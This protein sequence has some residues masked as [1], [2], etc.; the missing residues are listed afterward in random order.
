MLRHAARLLGRPTT[1]STV[2]AA[3]T[4]PA[5]SFA[6]RLG[7]DLS[8]PLLP[9]SYGRHDGGFGHGGASQ[10]VQVRYFSFGSD[11][12]NG[13]ADGDGS[14]DGSKGGDP[15]MATVIATSED[16][17]QPTDIDA[18]GIARVGTGDDA[19]RPS[20]LIS[21]P[22]LRRPLFPGMV[23]G[24]LLTDPATITAVSEMEGK[25][26]GLFLRKVIGWEVTRS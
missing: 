18:D 2:C 3:A 8:L 26:I 14:G 1:A 21:V 23:Q 25:Y 15:A 16:G 6:A 24:L 5:A 13:G 4:T 17:E 9:F 19:P 11:G 10:C 20:P 22:L 7:G 12:K